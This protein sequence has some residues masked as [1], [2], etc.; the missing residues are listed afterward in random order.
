[1]RALLQR[2]SRT[3]FDDIPLRLGSVQ[4]R[5]RPDVGL[6]GCTMPKKYLDVL[7]HARGH[8]FL[9]PDSE[10]DF[11][12]TLPT[13]IAGCLARLGATKGNRVTLGD[14]PI[15]DDA[16]FAEAAK[17]EVDEL[18]KSL[19]EVTENLLPYFYGMMDWGS[20]FWQANVIPPSTIAS[21]V[22]AT[23]AVTINPN[24]V[25]DEYCQ[26]LAL[27]EVETIAKAAKAIRYPVDAVGFFTFGGT[28]T[29]KYGVQVGAAR[30][31]DA[32]GANGQPTIILT[33]NCAHY[34]ARTVA[35]WS[36]IG[37]QNVVAVPTDRR[38]AMR[39]CDLQKEARKALRS[40]QAIAAIIGTVGTTDAF[41]LD[42]IGEIVR[43]RDELQREFCL[44]YTPHVHADA[45]AGWA[46]SFFNDYDFQKNKLGFARPTVN[47]LQRITTSVQNLRLADSVGIDSHKTGYAPYASS[48]ILF[49][50]PKSL[51]FL[52]CDKKSKARL[53]QTGRYHPGLFTLETTR[54]AVGAVGAWAA[55]ESLGKVGFQSILGHLVDMGRKLRER[56]NRIDHVQVL[57]RY[58]SGPVTILRVYPGASDVQRSKRHDWSKADTGTLHRLNEFNKQI[59]QYIYQTAMAGQGPLLGLT[60]GHRI[61]GRNG[62]VI[63]KAA[64]ALRDYIITPFVD[65]AHIDQVVDSI[66]DARA[67]VLTTGTWES[68][69]QLLAAGSV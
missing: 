26:G 5:T 66:A 48:A 42:D 6:G 61:I 1:M 54:S 24:L 60:E 29:L 57:N 53:F 38:H 68:V 4:D 8:T 17:V 10:K 34:S 63:Q 65:E 45:V 36:G 40:G 69:D 52:R 18:P 25:Q 46:W 16:A 37:V 47:L 31:A 49:K 51:E 33:S 9:Q 44:P 39:I 3:Q 41:G 62:E 28:G 14:P 12:S 22:A 11:E 30:A 35:E 13:S 32:G 67:H 19:E 15:L 23:L 21:I 56:L 20:P 43:V 64:V 55:F 59:F 27:V 2:N 7:D 50:S 58:N